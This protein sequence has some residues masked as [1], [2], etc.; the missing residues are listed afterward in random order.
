MQKSCLVGLILLAVV[1]VAASMALR[2]CY[3][4]GAE[5]GEDATIGALSHPGDDQALVVAS[6]RATV[7]AAAVALE[8]RG[9]AAPDGLALVSL[10]PLITDPVVVHGLAASEG[11]LYATGC[12]VSEQCGLVYVVDASTLDLR[13]KVIVPQDGTAVPGGIQVAGDAVWVWSVSVLSEETQVVILDKQ[14]L[15]ERARLVLEGAATALTVT[16]DG[17]YGSGRAGDWL[18]RWDAEGKQTLRRT[19]TTGA[20]YSD[21]EMLAGSFVCS[22]L[23]EDGSSVLDVMDPDQFSLLARHVSDTRTEAGEPVLAGAWAYLPGHLLFVPAGGDVPIVWTYALD[24]ISLEAFIPS[25]S[26]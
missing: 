12:D 19:N 23:L 2:R 21:C 6:A 16:S 1:L 3:L 9:D 26:R 22:G 7:A 14:T 20:V 8:N 18:Y 4:D 15:M 10:R 5:T 17:V 13:N 11:T 25:A 24:A